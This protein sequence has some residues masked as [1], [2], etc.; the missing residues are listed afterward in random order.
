MVFSLS[1]LALRRHCVGL[2]DSATPA[3]MNFIKYLLT[4]RLGK[5]KKL[6]I[7]S[8]SVV[9]EGVIFLV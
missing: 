5:G 4:E 8:E 6:V 2:Q 1:W 3:V 7:V 9:M